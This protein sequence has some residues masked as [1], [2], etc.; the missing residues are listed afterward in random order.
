V[1]INRFICASLLA[2]S[3]ILTPTQS[4]V[5]AAAWRVP[6]GVPP[7]N[8]GAQR[9][10]LHGVNIDD[11]YWQGAPVGG[12]GAGTF[13]RSYR[14]KFERWHLKTGTHKY[15][16]VPTNQF[17]VFAQPEGGSP[18]SVALAVGAPSDGSLSSWNWKYPAGDGEYAALYPK[19]WFSYETKTLP[20]K[21]TVEQFSPVLPNNYKETSYP[22]PSIAGPPKI[23]PTSP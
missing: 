10:E 7:A 9:T 5:P 23:P 19:S 8:P 1:R 18:V 6:I 17:A 12:F 13:S 21:L 14:G 15:Q 22:S 2:A 4:Q 16:D 11:G 20:V 3:S